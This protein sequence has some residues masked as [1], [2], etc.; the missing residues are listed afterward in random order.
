MGCS[1]GA[2]GL[3]AADGRTENAGRGVGCVAVGSCLHQSW[4]GEERL[5]GAS[6]HLQELLLPCG[7]PIL[8]V[9]ERYG[10]WDRGRWLLSWFGWN[11]PATIGSHGWI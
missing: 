2:C 3:L 4:L 8:I 1:N 10:A 6:L 9:M 5:W 11:E 7:P